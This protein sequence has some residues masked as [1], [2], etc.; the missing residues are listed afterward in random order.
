VRAVHRRQL[1][2][3]GGA[4]GVRDEGLLSSALHRPQQLWHYSDPRP[5]L[6]S[7]AATYAHGLAR[8]HPFLDGNKRTAFVVCRLFLRLNEADIDASREEK[9]RLFLDL[10]A[11]TVSQD[12]L[13]TWIR[14]RL[15]T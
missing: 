5:D 8:N 6:A 14:A 1:E 7:L 11:G 12:E 10:A 3:H 13:A 9:T 2:E 4:E 15:S